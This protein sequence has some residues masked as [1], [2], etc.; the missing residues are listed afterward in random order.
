MAFE[1]PRVISHTVN[2][3]TRGDN[4]LQHN[5]HRVNYDGNIKQASIVNISYFAILGMYVHIA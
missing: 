3:K 4:L 1:N 5:E 2:H